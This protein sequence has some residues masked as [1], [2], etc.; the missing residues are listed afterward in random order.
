M[1]WVLLALIVFGITFVLPI[2]SWVSIQ[3]L[4]RRI[5]DLEQTIAD[6]E[7]SIEL[8]KKRSASAEA[9]ARQ[10]AAAADAPARQAPEPSPAV[11]RDRPSPPVVSAPVSEKPAALPTPLPPPPPTPATPATP[12]TAPVENPWPERSASA[13]ASTRQPASADA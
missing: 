6:Q 11:A 7:H 13:D 12:V 10:A 4:K 2:A 3:G 8:L 9:S 1:E 5:G